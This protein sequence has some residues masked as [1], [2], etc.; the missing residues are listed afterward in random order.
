MSPILTPA[1]ARVPSLPKISRLVV[2]Q[3]HCAHAASPSRANYHRIGAFEGKTRY[4][5][6]NAPI[7][8]AEVHAR[9]PLLEPDLHAVGRVRVDHHSVVL[10]NAPDGRDYVGM[11]ARAGNDPRRGH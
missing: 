11:R 8:L 9:L 10:P 6:R 2:P 3:M 7:A 1:A 4:E 5:S